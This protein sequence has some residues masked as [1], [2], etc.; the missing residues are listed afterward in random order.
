MKVQKTALLCAALCVAMATQSASAAH[1]LL[2]EDFNDGLAGTR[3]SSV[4]QQEGVVG[5]D[6][7]VDYAFDYSSLGIANPNGSSDTTGAFLQ[8]NKNDD[9]PVAEGESY[10]I[11]PN[12]FMVSGPFFVEADMFVY[13][14][15]NSGSTEHG[16]IGVFL[17]NSNPV[18]P[19]EFGAVG[20]PLAWTYS[21]EGGDGSGDLGS[22]KEG[23]GS[24]TGYAGLN[25]YNDV[26][27][28]TIPGFQ[29]GADGPFGPA[30]PPNDRG[31]WV[32]TKIVSDGTTVSFFLN[33]ALIDSYDNSGGF[34]PG[35]NILLGGMDVF[36]SAN[37]GNGVIVDNVVV[38]IPEP[39]AL[40]LAGLSLAGLALGARR[41]S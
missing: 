29:T 9:G 38:G 27:A 7:S 33:G 41:R 19:Y 8:F 2:T 25:N 5:P 14:D 20:G 36:N 30:A 24:S 17:D 32:K 28:G 3:W 12:G 39:T 40:A 34:Y 21:G 16:M 13:N 37:G 31:S 26:P 22:F 4:S 11:Y 18:S 1:L 23:D 6:G 35:G 15:G 10:S